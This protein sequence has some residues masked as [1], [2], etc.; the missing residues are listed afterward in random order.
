[1]VTTPAAVNEVEAVIVK[2]GEVALVSLVTVMPVGLVTAVR[3]TVAA[4][5]SEPHMATI[6][7]VQEPAF[8]ALV[9]PGKV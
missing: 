9:V 7:V 3:S 6:C 5:C 1:M 8:A 2:V 4:T